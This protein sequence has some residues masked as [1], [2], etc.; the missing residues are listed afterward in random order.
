M[1]VFINETGDTSLVDAQR[2]SYAQ[3]KDLPGGMPINDHPGIWSDTMAVPYSGAADYMSYA[4][5]SDP[6]TG[7]SIK[8]PLRRIQRLIAQLSARYEPGAI[9]CSQS[10]PTHTCSDPDRPFRQSPLLSQASRPH[11]H[12]LNKDGNREVGGGLFNNDTRSFGVENWDKNGVSMVEKRDKN[13]VNTA[14]N[15]DK[16][17]ESIAENWNENGENTVENGVNTV[18]NWNKNGTNTVERRTVVEKGNRLEINQN[19]ENDEEVEENSQT[20]IEQMKSATLKHDKISNE[21]NRSEIMYRNVKSP[22]LLFRN[23]DTTEVSK[24][25]GNFNK[26]GSEREYKHDMLSD[27]HSDVCVLEAAEGMDRRNLGHDQISQPPLNLRTEPLYRSAGPIGNGW[28]EQSPLVTRSTNTDRR[29]TY[30]THF[31]PP[32][33]TF[34]P[35]TYRATPF[36]AV[37]NAQSSSLLPPYSASGYTPQLQ[38]LPIQ[39]QA[40][41]TM[42]DRNR[43]VPFMNEQ[44]EL[45]HAA[46]PALHTETLNIDVKSILRE[47][48]REEFASRSSAPGSAVNRET[49]S[50]GRSEKLTTTSDT[51]LH[52]N[53]T[54]PAAMVKSVDNASAQNDLQSLLRQLVQ[55]QL[56]SGNVKDNTQQSELIISETVN[57]EQFTKK[58]TGSTVGQTEAVKTTS[59]SVQCQAADLQFTVKALVTDQL[60]ELILGLAWL[61][62]QAAEWNFG[63]RCL[64]IRGHELPL[65]GH[66]Q[67]W[68]C[69]R[70]TTVKS[71]ARGTAES[72]VE[73]D[74][75]S[76]TEQLDILK[77]ARGRSV[78]GTL[79]TAKDLTC[80][81]AP[82]T[83]ARGIPRDQKTMKL[84]GQ[85]PNWGPTS[86]NR[87]NSD[88][89]SPFSVSAKQVKS[90]GQGIEIPP[91]QF[92]LHGINF[93]CITSVALAQNRA[94]SG[95]EFFRS[96]RKRIPRWNK[97]GIGIREVR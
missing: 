38:P 84:S 20:N 63:K 72:P 11:P 14:E 49:S 90:P 96:R 6:G 18:E 22:G 69:R 62:E 75:L 39:N 97:Q 29:E 10:L 15:W 24:Q 9:T 7:S 46:R 56:A 68:N 26:N 13:G 55:E 21:T 31:N 35:S 64:Q 60:S 34:A 81:V 17:G 79:S 33:S 54:Y 1:D 52:A 40:L 8:T 83:K 57:G 2:P 19:W 78:E 50:D 82:T 12:D 48:I 47:L 66:K 45:S 37:G 53:H 30:P 43:A 85:I 88:Q 51:L 27:T 86:R 67:L 36:A 71:P 94:K 80:S 76:G 59:V 91:D 16:N 23:F 93:E 70:I 73:M 5:A 89:H 61:Q 44:T 95:G 42:S 41:R 87:R 32:Q 28:E 3:S 4:L 25:Q 92:V 77:E 74:T 58:T 65:S